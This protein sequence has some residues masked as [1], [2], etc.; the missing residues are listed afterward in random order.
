M[1]ELNVFLSKQL[2]NGNY[3]AK[4]SII[5]ALSITLKGDQTANPTEYMEDYFYGEAGIVNGVASS[6]QFKY[7]PLDKE[8][9]NDQ[10]FCDVDNGLHKELTPEIYKKRVTLINGNTEIEIMINCEILESLEDEVKA[11]NS[12]LTELVKQGY[13]LS[14]QQIDLNDILLTNEEDANS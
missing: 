7:L 9:Q 10:Y 3:Y 4:P 6:G 2:D 8:Q 14:W 1:N 11:M 5:F 12:D 13:A